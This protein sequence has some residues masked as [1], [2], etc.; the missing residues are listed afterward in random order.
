RAGQG[1]PQPWTDA[2]T[3]A[4]TPPGDDIGDALDLEIVNTSLRAENPF[5][6][7]IFGTLQWVFAIAAMAGL[8]WLAILVVLGWLQLSPGQ[9]PRLGPLPYPFL[10]LAAGLLIGSL[11]SLVAR[12][13]GRIGAQR[14]KVLVEARLRDSVGT[15]V[16]DRLVAPV[17]Q[18]LDRHRSTREHL[19]AARKPC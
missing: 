6:W 12:A 16:R 11:L 7:A 3:N 13:I 2:V 8:I 5:W 18:V 9:A 1:L 14:R 17:Q 10:L 19:E 15:V 4:A